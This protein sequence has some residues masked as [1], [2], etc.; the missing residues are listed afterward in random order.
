[1]P[2]VR[3]TAPTANGVTAKEPGNRSRA[4]QQVAYYIRNVV[5]RNT[6]AAGAGTWLGS[7][8]RAGQPVP[9][10]RPSSKYLSKGKAAVRNLPFAALA[11]PACFSLALH[12][13]VSRPKS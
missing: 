8:V 1:M 4:R 6:T 12:N 2:H 9:T 5:G 13:L 10:H 11:P 7:P 3:W